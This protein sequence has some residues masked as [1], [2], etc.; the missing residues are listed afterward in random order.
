LGLY[1]STTGADVDIPELGIV[2]AHPSVNFNI[3]AQFSAEEIR[4][5]ES[6]T[7]AIVS[8]ILLWRKAP[9]GPI[10]PASEYDPDFVEIEELSTGSGNVLLSKND[11]NN[12]F[13]YGI[14]APGSFSGNPKKATVVFDEPFPSSNYMINITGQDGR[15]WRYESKTA[16][17]FIINSQANQSLSGEVSWLAYSNEEL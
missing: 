3:S 1:I 5:A 4:S 17:G 11:I 10:Q 7:A 13:K 12:K 2:I 14:I 8:G 6:L 16:S 9:A 15:S